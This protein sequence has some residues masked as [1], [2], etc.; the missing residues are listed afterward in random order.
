[1]K[2]DSKF[3]NDIFNDSTKNKKDYITTNLLK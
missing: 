1:M 3:I 2:I